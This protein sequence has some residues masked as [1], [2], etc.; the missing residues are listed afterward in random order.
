MKNFIPV[1]FLVFFSFLG[2]AQSWTG[3]YT[4]TVEN[5]KSKE[6]VTVFFNFKDNKMAMDL[7]VGKNPGLVR[8]IFDFKNMTMTSLAEKEGAPRYAM[9][10]KLT[11]D[12]VEKQPDEIKLTQT[13]EQQVVD[14][15]NCRK[16]IAE[17]NGERT[18]MWLTSDLNLSYENTAGR[19]PKTKNSPVSGYL[20][21]LR[22]WPGIVGFPVE[23]VSYKI[24]TPEEKSIT[25]FSDFKEGKVNEN[26][27]DLRS[28]QVIEMPDSG[29]RN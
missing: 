6:P 17:S 12:L 13:D 7:V 26:V 1:L 25:R 29:N 11:D 21:G 27:F 19:M 5:S 4:M 20:S 2:N 10:V 18:E 15:F 23:M 22:Q 14:G 8:T 3:S 24:N 16:A 9:V 28:Y